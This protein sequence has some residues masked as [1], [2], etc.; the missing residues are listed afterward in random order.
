MRPPHLCWAAAAALS[1]CV[2]SSVRA[3]G[4]AP[5]EGDYAPPPS[6]EPAPRGGSARARG[7]GGGRTPDVLRPGTRPMWVDLAFGPDFHGISG[8]RRPP[9]F[10]GRDFD[11]RFALGV[12][13]GYH[14]EGTFEGPAIGASLEQT[15]GKGFYTI[16]PAGKFWWDIMIADMGIYA[17][18]FAKLGYML[19]TASGNSAHAF[20]IGIGGE[21]RVVLDDRWLA[22]LR[23]PQI[24]LLIGDNIGG[25]TVSVNVHVMIGGGV[26]F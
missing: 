24:D 11:A 8:G 2:P 25:D 23:L 7:G 1:L 13:F 5:P 21:G 15:F 4:Y 9:G 22:L 18:P 17:A 12:D 14:F 16:N 20:N 3:Q 6:P 26:T 19:G 10:R